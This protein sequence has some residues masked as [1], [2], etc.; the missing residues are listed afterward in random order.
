MSLPMVGGPVRGGAYPQ[1]A[2]PHPCV[3]A[4][5]V[6]LEEKGEYDLNAVRLCFQVWVQ[7]P[8]GTGHL[9]L[10]PLVVSQPIYDNREPGG[11]G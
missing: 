4:P 3:L 10:L 1:R 7:D 5:T 11:R 8:A 9:M 2:G 6:S